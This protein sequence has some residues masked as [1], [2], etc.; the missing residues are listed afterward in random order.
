MTILR[1]A[2]KKRIDSARHDFSFTQAAN[3]SEE[4][5]VT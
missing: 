5:E 1:L 3:P 2:E 4:E